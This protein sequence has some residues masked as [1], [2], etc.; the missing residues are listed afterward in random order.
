LV[1]VIV[2]IAIVGFMS[3][4][5]VTLVGEKGPDDIVERSQ[6]T[7]VSHIR[8][9]ENKSMVT[10]KCGG[11]SALFF[12][13]GFT[14]NEI[15]ETYCVNSFGKVVDQ[16]ISVSGLTQGRV[17]FVPPHPIVRNSQNFLVGSTTIQINSN[18][19]IDIF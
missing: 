3:L 8:E 11:L 15:Y 9:A 18:G 13:V 5:T 19:S 4:S 16:Q 12:G 14:S 7:L 2:V 17:E 10:E 6:E 1:E